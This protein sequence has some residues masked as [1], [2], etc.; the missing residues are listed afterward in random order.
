[1]GA[2]GQ[3]ECDHSVPNKLHD[4]LKE[5]EIN[6]S[7][8]NKDMTSQL[9]ASLESSYAYL[10]RLQYTMAPYQ[11]FEY[12]TRE[13]LMETTE[14]S[15]EK[16]L[17]Y[18]EEELNRLK[19]EEPENIID[20][21]KIEASIE[22]LTQIL[23]GDFYLD[24]YRRVCMD[25]PFNMVSAPCRNRFRN[26]IYYNKEL[27]LEEISSNSN[28]FETIPLILIDSLTTFDILIKPMEKG[29][30]FIFN[31]MNP[32]DIYDKHGSQIF[33]ETIVQFVPNGF[34]TSIE[35]NPDKIVDNMISHTEIPSWN[36]LLISCLGKDGI[37]FIGIETEKNSTRSTLLECSIM[38]DGLYIH[39]DERTLKSLEVDGH[40]LSVHIIFVPYIHR[41]EFYTNRGIVS[42]RRYNIKTSDNT[43]TDNVE[44]EFFVLMDDD[45][46]PYSMP[47]PTKNIIISKYAGDA[48]Y[49]VYGM[50]VKD[51]YPN[52]Y[53]I[54]DDDMCDSDKY[55]V[56]Y[57][58]YEDRDRK[59]TPLHDFYYDYLKNH[60]EKSI[61]EIINSIYFQDKSSRLYKNGD[62]MNSD[63]YEEFYD[64]FKKMIEYQDYNYVYNTIDFCHSY[65]GDD[66]PLQYKISKM[67]AFVRGDYH[68]LQD[69][70]LREKRMGDLYHFFVY[71][72]DL[73]KRFRRS[74][75]METNENPFAFASGLEYVNEST[76][77]ALKVVRNLDY[78]IESEILIDDASLL[79]LNVHEGDY[80]KL[81]DDES[82]YV[83][84]FQND[85]L[86]HHLPLRVFVDGIWS[87]D[88]EIVHRYGMDYLYVPARLV[89]D[90]SYIMIEREYVMSKPLKIPF[91]SLDEREWCEIHLIETPM[92][93][94]TMN[95][96][97]VETDS[98]V[99]LDNDEYTIELVRD[100]VSYSMHDER[101]DITN[102]YGIVTDIR[103]RLDNVRTENNSNFVILVNKTSYLSKMVM[104]RKGYPRFYLDGLNT[105]EDIKFVRMYFN[106]RLMPRDFYKYVE[107]DN[108][109]FIQSRVFARKGDTFVFEISPYARERI[110]IMEELPSDYTV[111]FTGILNKPANPQYYEFFLNGR[112]L[113][114]EN[115]FEFGP[116]HAVFRGTH[117]RHCL[118]IYEKERDYEYFGYE[119]ISLD[120]TTTQYFFTPFELINKEFIT[121]E[122]IQEI[123]TNY[124]ESVKDKR[125]KIKANDECEEDNTFE[126]S[127]NILEDVAIFYYEDLLPLGL[128]DP[129]KRQFNNRFLKGVYPYL[130]DRYLD[131]ETNCIFLNPDIVSRSADGNLT[132]YDKITMSDT[133]DERMITFLCGENDINE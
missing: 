35:L 109:H 131:D 93:S 99:Q 124:I 48:Y 23:Y 15:K 125:V 107:V 63:W 97:S 46:N 30:R 38:D 4:L 29:T 121:K 130:C 92:I 119:S 100:K 42:A 47:I 113:G 123:I 72:T 57:F 22:K 74:T 85:D 2:I 96:I 75:I 19:E 126:V 54:K 50:G 31:S 25:T 91:T 16:D 62:E 26:S 21:E 60:Y 77:G 101:H 17:N 94:Y 78:D 81:I 90:E 132:G 115:V 58:Y 64:L 33:H 122:E 83:F 88:T 70:V 106:G 84:V 128:A 32:V 52:M 68:T 117:S 67:R 36:M 95:D 45:G 127:Y 111:D 9:H 7:Y 5:V 80:I 110:H 28:L 86:L 53:Q 73:R 79:D 116:H 41:H 82:R 13:F 34:Y 59:Y 114:I 11:R 76:D 12:Q 129:N 8:T 105:S 24:K 66:I 39:L 44:S 102:K 71:N 3:W 103:I 89:T 49:P 1:M 43:Y 87:A 37:P 27:T 118:E 20:I 112:R 133:D 69:Y 120:G 98:G 108:I 14:N 18:Y 55:I 51:F 56:Y 104:T 6:N 10:R 65:D 61:E 40:T